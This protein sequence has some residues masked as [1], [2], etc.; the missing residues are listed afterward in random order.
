MTA[1]ENRVIL[2]LIELADLHHPT[3]LADAIIKQN[4]W[5]KKV[6]P[7]EEI[8]DAAG[9]F[10]IRYQPLKNFEGSL[11]A[12][13]VK[14]D[15]IILINSNTRHHRKR[16]TLGHELG[17]FLLP[18]HGHSMT[19]TKQDLNA[20]EN[21]KLDNYNRIESEANQFSAELLMPNSLCKKQKEFNSYPSIVGITNIAEHF[22]VSFQASAIRFADI[23]DCP[24]ALIISKNNRVVFGYKRNDF[25]FWLKVGKRDASIPLGSATAEIGICEPNTIRS[26]ESLSDIWFE[27]NRYF[28]LPDYLIEEILVQEEGYI[29]TILW[30]DE[31]VEEKE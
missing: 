9:I 6:I 31:E 5:I 2:D 22:D 4:N 30:F 29:A 20:R 3:E 15:G 11:I 27:S 12:N 7:L 16:F 8:A 1:K 10:E 21:A 24:I 18:R 19:C 25:P 14:S 26:T 28:K 17:H 23:H 13:D